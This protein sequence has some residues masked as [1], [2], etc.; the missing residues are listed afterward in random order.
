[1]RNAVDFLENKLVNPALFLIA[2]CHYP[3][4]P[5]QRAMMPLPIT[6]IQCYEVFALKKHIQ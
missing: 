2:F 5:N 4:S 6:E 1:M 3:R